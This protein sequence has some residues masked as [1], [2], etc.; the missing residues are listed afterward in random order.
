MHNLTNNIRIYGN[1]GKSYRIPT[2]YDQ[3]YESPVEQGNPNLKPEYSWNYELGMRYL[4]KNFMFEGNLFY[5]NNKDLIDWIFDTQDSVWRSENVSTVNTAGLELVV[6]YQKVVPLIG[7]EFYIDH[8]SVSYNKLNQEKEMIDE[9]SRYAL[10]HLTDQVIVSS[11]IN[12]YKKLKTNLNF[13]YLKRIDQDGYILL[14][15][16]IYWM[17]KKYNLFIEATNITNT[18]YTEVFTPMPGRWFRGGLILTLGY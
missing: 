1:I 8:L 13:R 9:Q 17:D 2:F 12:I 15:G 11:V 5:R 10:E 3:Y 14:D 16:R 7:E 18:E 4:E 6:S